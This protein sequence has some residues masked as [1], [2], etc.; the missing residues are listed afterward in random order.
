MLINFNRSLELMD[1]FETDNLRLLY[2]DFANKF[3]GTYKSYEYSRL[4]TIIQGEKVIT[5]NKDILKYDTNK[6]LLLPPESNIHM[7]INQPTKAVVFE[8]NSQLIKQANEK[9]SNEYAIDYKTLSQ[10]NYYIGDENIELKEILSRINNKLLKKNKNFEC[11]I[12]LY[13]Q[14]LVYNLISS[15]GAR[16]VLN[17]ELNNPVNLAI[18]YMNDNCMQSISISQLSYDLNMS[19]ANFCQ[20]FKRITNMTPNEYLTNVKLEKAKSL[21]MQT[22]VTEVAFDLGYEN[23]SYFISIFKRKYGITPKQYQKIN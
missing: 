7:E 13:A 10:E 20:Y 22:S 4:C 9:V 8:L 15:K 21:L 2:Y 18:R 16:Q 3:T 6:Y 19:E 5:I 23:I 12:D 1:R 11:I 14:E 17:L